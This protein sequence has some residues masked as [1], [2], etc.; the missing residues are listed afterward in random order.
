MSTTPWYIDRTNKSYTG[1]LIQPTDTAL[2]TPRFM[3]NQISNLSVSLLEFVGLPG[4]LYAPVDLTDYTGLQIGVGALDK[5]PTAG[6]FAMTAD[7]NGTGLT[8]L[9]FDVS[10]AALQ[11]ALNANAAVSGAGGVTVVASNSFYTIT[12]NSTN[13]VLTFTADAAGLTPPCTIT[14]SNPVVPAVDVKGVY[15]LDIT[16]SPYAYGDEFY[17][18]GVDF[19]NFTVSVSSEVI[20]LT[21][22]LTLT[23][24]AVEHQD[25][26]PV[27]GRL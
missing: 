23:E 10:A 4:V 22:A 5:R 3:R 14:L 1:F 20:T 12:M 11:S 16:Q 6:T 19:R 15:T 7:G 27:L 24:G 17:P 18:Q 13:T 21:S 26:R 25:A 9:P 8:A 2:T